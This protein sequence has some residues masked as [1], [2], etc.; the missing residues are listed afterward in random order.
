MRKIITL[1]LCLI[2]SPVFAGQTPPP[3]VSGNFI[4]NQ[5]NQWAA[6][7]AAAAHNKIAGGTAY[8]PRDPAYG[9][10]CAGYNIYA[11]DSSTT[12]F[13]YT[14]PFTGSS[15]TDNSNFFVFYEATNNSGTATILN[16][17]QFT[18]TGV[19]SGVGGTITLNSAVPTG[20]TLVIAHDDSAGIVAAST[21]SV[22]T[23]GYVIIP[24]KC[25][26]YGSQANGTILHEASS[27]IG[28]S[29]NPNSTYH[30]DG[31]TPVLYVISPR[32]FAPNF[33][34]NISGINQQFFEGFQI[35]D[36]LVTGPG[37]LQALGFGAV[38][39]LIGANGS[40][41]AGGGNSPGIVV[42]YMTFLQGQV[43][44][45]AP[46][47]GNSGYIFAVARFNNF[48]ANTT[49]GIY[50]PLSDQQILGNDF[51][52][53][54]EFGSYG[55]AGGMVVGPAEG[56]VGASGAA[57]FLSNRF[58]FNLEG[59]VVKSGALINMEG[60][61]FD[62][63]S[64]CGLDLN[65]FWAQINMTGGW[66]RGN[67]NGG[68]AFQGN[69]TAGQD[70]HICF[71]GSTNSG[72][73]YVSNVKFLS[74]YS[75]GS[76]A[77]LGSNNATTPPYTLDFNG[78]PSNNNNI[79][80]NGGEAQFGPSLTNN[81]SVTD[82]AIYRQGQPSNLVIDIDGQAVQGKNANGSFP[83]QSRGLAANSWSG[84]TVFGDADSYNA[85]YQ[86]LTNGYA[87]I[88]AKGLGLGPTYYILNDFSHLDCD[89]VN[90]EIVPNSNST[91]QGNNFVTWLP[92]SEDVGYGGGFYTQHLQDTSTCR[93]GALT[94][95]AV[96]NAYKVY[97]QAGTQTGSWSNDSGYGGSYGVVS[98]TNGS[99]LA[100]STTTNG[101]PIYLWFRM[102]GSNG[103]TFTYRLDSGP[104]TT[105]ATQGNNAF[106]YSPTLSSFTL[107][108]IRIPVSVAGAH[109][110]NIAVTSSTSSSNTV[111]IEGI[112]TPPGVP[113][114]GSSPTVVLG[115]Q[116]Y[117]STTYPTAIAAFN[118]D[119]MTQANQ[120]AADGLSV[121]FANVQKYFN[122]STDIL[123]S[124]FHYNSTGQGHIAEAFTSAIQGVLN[125]NRALDPLD[126]GA[127]CN[128]QLF[129]Q[130]FNGDPLQNGVNTIAN[131][132]LVTVNNYTFQPGV[133]T[134]FGGGDVGKVFSVGYDTDQ[135]PTTYVAAVVAN[136]ATF[137]NGSG[138]FTCSSSTNCA[139]L[140]ANMVSNTSNKN[141]VMGGYPSNPN[142]P[143]T[144]RDDTF[145]IQSASKASQLGGGIVSLPANCLIHNLVMANHTALVGNEGGMGYNQLTGYPNQDA[146]P[147]YVAFNGFS[148]D[149]DNSS[150]SPVANNMGI[151]LNTTYGTRFK[152]FVLICASFPYL[153][154]GQ[155]SAGFGFTAQAGLNADWVTLDHVGVTQCPVGFGTPLDWSKTITATGSVTG[156]TMTITAITSNA[157]ANYPSNPSDF[158][159]VGRTVTGTGIAA[160]SVINSAPPGGAAGTYILSQSSSATG[161]ITITS[162]P[163]NVSGTGFI[164]NGWFGEN[165]IG[166][167]GSLTDFNLENTVFTNNYNTNWYDGPS[168]SGFGSN[169]SHM[170]G[171]RFESGGYGVIFDSVTN[172][173]L[174]GVQWQATQCAVATVGSG[175]GHLQITGGWMQ[176]NDC[177]PGS[178]AYSQVLLGGTGSDISFSGVSM[179][180][181]NFGGAGAPSSQQ[182]KYVLSTT[183]SASVDYVIFD[184]GEE[185]QGFNTAFENPANT[186]ITHYKRNI[187]GLPVIDTTVIPTVSGCS[188]SALNGGIYSGG[189]TSGTTSTCTLT[190]TLPTVPNGWNCV[191]G[192]LTTGVNFAMSA[193]TQT[194]CALTGATTSGDKLWFNGTPH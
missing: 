150:G 69:T 164:R 90:T 147:L 112:G 145:A 132:P 159:A 154:Q 71:N 126:F 14:I 53:N 66:F 161:T 73:L 82:F 31:T 146:T 42:Q 118:T 135:G 185:R 54:G 5:S 51:V 25:T 178:S 38:P 55:N 100:L 152:D 113:L 180:Y 81:A 189:V 59:I 91:L 24:D 144:A 43:G 93:M 33:G 158:L 179:D 191:G 194:T 105:V 46:T 163:P 4:I 136:G 108:G 128:T 87:A 149:V 172:T 52:S 6:L 169:S 188:F 45:G 170:T 83:S 127:T 103:G 16:T 64:G 131:S 88:V 176:G 186:A 1:L 40:S 116:A 106:T 85:Q 62:G 124:T 151:N 10:L 139:A 47:G 12:T 50:G 122:F 37:P 129:T 58:E 165:G 168:S 162:S 115:G 92:S 34:I 22:A 160:N 120:L 8:D 183:G 39:V 17:S 123:G 78:T 175:W 117:T 138:T 114:P 56:A 166:V 121:V 3:G 137:T 67:A 7:A 133:A 27:L 182:S 187:G 97:G 167:N 84:Y 193:S 11:G 72:G 153:P 99:T 77:P 49:A 15:S 65:T 61:Q 171:G 148:D 9:A 143:A 29:F 74:N 30:G 70:A 76:T 98:Q 48:T 86:P 96:P 181:H 109:T 68:G 79:Q 119:Q 94:W 35:T 36:L 13:A 134:Q 102:N 89:V 104:T 142:N 28:E 184:G 26:I 130:Q 177:N 190:L 101:G 20:S 80:F 155:S 75:E 140:G 156:N 44:F 157:L 32:G 192:D 111:I 110:V 23:G 63:N 21:A 60:N 107:G 173:Q 141:A 41:G 125:P 2:C 19:N 18:V 174:T 95:M 57:R